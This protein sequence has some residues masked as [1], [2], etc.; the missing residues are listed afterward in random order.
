MQEDKTHWAESGAGVTDHRNGW[1]LFLIVSF[2]LLFFVVFAFFRGSGAYN[3]H[4][5]KSHSKIALPIKDQS[6]CTHFFKFSKC[7]KCFS[8]RLTINPPA[9]N[10]TCLYH[11][12]EPP[13]KIPCPDSHLMS[14]STVPS[15]ITLQSITGNRERKIPEMIIGLLKHAKLY[16]RYFRGQV[17]WIPLLILTKSGFKIILNVKTAIF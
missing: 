16:A 8:E 14:I 13:F 11:D 5:I 1:V 17:F 12:W 3:M 7:M 4:I 10:P 9:I 2:L 6:P 15:F